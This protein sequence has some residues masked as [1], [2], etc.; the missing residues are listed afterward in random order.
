MSAPDFSRLRLRLLEGGL[1]PRFVERT[2]RELQEHSTDIECD[3]LNAGVP[4]SAAAAMA[5]SALGSDAAIAA[6]A[7]EQRELLTWV[8]RW[9]RCARSLRAAAFCM[10]LPAVPVVYCTQRGGSIARWGASVSLAVLATGA[11]L[12]IMQMTLAGPG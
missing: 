6:A 8:H 4:A 9:P 1:A 3:A 5:R 11:W 12:L 7:L 10:I 2:I